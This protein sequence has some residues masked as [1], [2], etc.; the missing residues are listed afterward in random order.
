MKSSNAHILD[1]LRRYRQMAAKITPQRE[2]EVVKILQP[3]VNRLTEIVLHNVSIFRDEIKKQEQYAQKL[4]LNTVKLK[5][6]EKRYK[7]NGGALT[8][9]FENQ[10]RAKRI[11]DSK[12][13]LGQEAL[14]GKNLE[15]L[16]TEEE[17][18]LQEKAKIGEQVSL[19]GVTI[20]K[21]GDILNSIKNAQKQIKK[22]LEKQE[23]IVSDLQRKEEIYCEELKLHISLP[24]KNESDARNALGDY[25]LLKHLSLED[26]KTVISFLDEIVPLTIGAKDC[27]DLINHGQYLHLFRAL[28][29]GVS[30]PM[31]LYKSFNGVQHYTNKR[32]KGYQHLAEGLGP[33]VVA[34][35]HLKMMICENFSN[36]PYQHFTEYS[37]V[38]NNF[39]IQWEANSKQV[40]PQRAGDRFGLRLPS[41]WI[42]NTELLDTLEQILTQ[43]PDISF[44]D[45]AIRLNESFPNPS[46][47]KRR[48]E[49]LAELKR[50]HEETPEQV[51]VTE[52]RYYM[53]KQMEQNEE[54]A[55]LQR[56]EIARQAELDRQYAEEARR[57]A[58][59]QEARRQEKMR[60]EA[61][62]QE[63]MQARED[64]VRQKQAQ[65]E[66]ERQ[67]E[68]NRMNGVRKCWNCANYGKCSSKII[69][70]GA[71]LNCGGYRPK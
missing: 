52:Q 47:Q 71:G 61:M 70:S 10:I 33:S 27:D 59:R 40:F 58:E 53:Q 41:F 46:E 26:R 29:A 69:G 6:F 62:I 31:S 25:D 2:A 9:N 19:L 65:R 21:G 56:E 35:E 50:L 16:V 55:R 22:D 12:I 15:Q 39:Y 68:I 60:Y 30:H 44:P 36:N 1:D 37:A 54:N 42:I 34:D 57:E 14:A 48:Q 18:L 63:Q 4:K 45:L 13:T 32:D 11:R 23:K 43:E 64:A 24:V 7:N 28:C 49:N 17:N 3:H 66:A 8:N 5:E 38:A 20:E 51:M 67:A